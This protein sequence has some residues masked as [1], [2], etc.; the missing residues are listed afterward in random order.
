MVNESK[1]T[2][3]PEEG[4][5]CLCPLGGVMEIISKRWA[6]LIIG[7]IGN[8]KKLRYND[9]MKKLGSISPK[10]LSDRLKELEMADLI[11]R[12]AYPEIPPRVEYSLT[13]DGEELRKALM[14]LMQWIHSRAHA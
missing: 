9:I 7:A 8:S 14:P 11:R 2:C 10:S 12:E 3:A 6:L 13:D 4:E 1:R 5:V